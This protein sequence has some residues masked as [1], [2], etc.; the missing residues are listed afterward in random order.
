[1]EEFDD[2]MRAAA[3]Q[4]HLM[5]CTILY[6]YAIHCKLYGVVAT[7]VQYMQLEARAAAATCRARAAADPERAQRRTDA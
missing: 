3:G 1:M 5:Y 7:S 6:N 4:I 2:V